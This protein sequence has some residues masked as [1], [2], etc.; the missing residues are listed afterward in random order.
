MK[1]AHRTHDP[2]D[3]VESYRQVID[4]EREDPMT[5]TS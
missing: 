5:T 4:T 1:N 2:R 3:V